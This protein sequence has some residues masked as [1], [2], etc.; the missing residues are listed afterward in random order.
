MKVS[1]LGV[2]SL[3]EYPFTI[4]GESVP[5]LAAVLD[6]V[7]GRVPLLIELKGEDSLPVAEKVAEALEGYVGEYAVQSFNPYYLYRFRKISPDT[8]LGFLSN[9]R[10]GKGIY[11]KLFAFFSANLLFNF[12]FRPD[13]I[14]YGFSEKLPLSVKLCRRLGAKTLAWTVKGENIYS[15]LLDHFDGVIAENI[16][17]NKGAP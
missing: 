14:S 5:T 13:F 2:D 16:P 12:T 11:N 15:G 1:C 4:G 9:R 17:E 10:H 8:P 7:K 6:L 3:A